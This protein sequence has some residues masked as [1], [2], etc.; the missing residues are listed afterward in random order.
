[1]EEVIEMSTQCIIKYKRLGISSPGNKELG[2]KTYYHNKILKTKSSFCCKSFSSKV[3][4]TYDKY[5]YF[6]NNNAE[7][8]HILKSQK[9]KDPDI[10]Q[11]VEWDMPMYVVNN[12]RIDADYG[13]GCKGLHNCPYC[14]A[15][16][17]TQEFKR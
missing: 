16:I 11:I 13:P 8:I 15:Q 5:D 6:T 17:F 3:V 7:E 1:M 14:D 2:L 12:D 10:I 4:E 9:G